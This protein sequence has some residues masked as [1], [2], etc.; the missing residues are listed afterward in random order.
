MNDQESISRREALRSSASILTAAFALPSIPGLVRSRKQAIGAC[1][2]SIGKNS[3]VSGVELA[4]KIGLDGLQVNMGSAAN[5]M[6]LRDPKV[7]Q[8]YREAFKKYN[9]R[10]SGLAL[11][12]LNNVPYKSDPVTDQWVVDS[13]D[14]AKAL[15]VSVILLAFFG[16]NDLKNDPEG[17]RVVIDKL[18][19]VMP[20]AEAA[21]IT[22]GIESWLNAEEHLYIIRQV[23]SANLK[24][25]YDVANAETM[26]YP[27]Y[28]ELRIL[29]SQKMICEV[30]AKE[31]GFLL[32]QGK[33]DFA[34]VNKCLD[35][36]NY[37]GWVQIEGAVPK[38]QPVFESYLHNLK[39][40]RSALS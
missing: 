29:G 25:Y 30:H 39:F 40:L 6:H 12:E 20:K 11:G 23:G 13:I 4:S 21:G 32:G 3:D 28:E 27:V 34:E 38:G 14:V 15:K 5:Q 9:V 1:D 16:K 24:V 19:K 26:G 35:E 10:C 31:N 2:W 18:K 37:K 8:Q 36:I 17:T 22:I 33:I 7:Q